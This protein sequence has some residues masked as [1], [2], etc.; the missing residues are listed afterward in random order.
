MLP[1]I[2]AAAARPASTFEPP[3]HATTG[4]QPF[5][6]N[7]RLSRDALDWIH[8]QALEPSRTALRSSGL[9]SAGVFAYLNSGNAALAE[10]YFLPVRMS[11]ASGNELLPQRMQALIAGLQQNGLQPQVDVFLRILDSDASRRPGEEVPHAQL[12]SQLPDVALI[13]H[14]L[15]RGELL[16]AK[17]DQLQPGQCMMLSINANNVI[18]V[19]RD[20]EQMWVF[21]ATLNPD[22]DAMP[23][24]E[25]VRNAIRDTTPHRLTQGAFGGLYTKCVNGEAAERF[26]AACLR[27]CHTQPV[28]VS[29]P[30]LVSLLPSTA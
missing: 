14:R 4:P 6:A 18:A 26:L 12:S 23:L 1:S 5:D 13:E 25:V 29:P 30:E 17:L 8:V 27:E 28:L 21:D 3:T 19:A 15:D 24:R 10:H 9:V 16:K 22:K 2:G 11:V 20:R 7:G